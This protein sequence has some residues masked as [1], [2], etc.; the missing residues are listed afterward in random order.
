V[1]A[2][3]P[4]RLLAAAVFSLSASLAGAQAA[5][6]P[7]PESKTG[8]ASVPKHWSK[9]KYPESVPEGAAYHIVERGDSLWEVAA[10]YLKNPLLWPQVWEQNKY[11]TD[12]HWIYP[13]D[14]IILK[15][16][17]VVA[18]K[19]GEMPELPKEPEPAPP[20]PETPV[21]PP[22]Y[23]ATEYLTLQCASLVAPGREDE[24]FKVI[25]AEDGKFKSAYSERDILYLNKGSNGGVKPGDVFSVHRAAH[26]VK[27]AGGKTVG[28]K[29]MTLGWLRVILTKETSATAIVEQSC[30]S[31]IAAGDYLKPFEKVE[32]PQVLRQD[33]PDRLT[34]GSG[35]G[36]GSIIDIF[37]GQIAAAA[38]HL[39]TLD[40]GAEAG[41]APG[42]TM[43]IFRVVY[44]KVPTSRRVLGELV[45][46][47]T[48]ARFA[49]AKVLYSTDA[50][51]N[52][53]LVE[54]R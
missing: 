37:D 53:D 26:K 51:L 42:K 3:A 9:Y 50:I 20:P 1:T 24:S 44:P 52:G 38:G 10:R 12:S 17:E 4:S 34:P 41:L 8:P 29:I 25:G 47:R 27:S 48:Q 23:P 2:K 31:E 19:A 33:P 43:T 39:V 32:V 14:P 54:L 28:L 6:A 35:R 30:N 18:D 16:I 11:I 40:V 22:L 5:P 15:K 45:V 36:Q 7:G 21:P 49:L 46:L 13:G